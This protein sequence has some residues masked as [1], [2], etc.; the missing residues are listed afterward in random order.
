MLFKTNML[1]VRTRAGSVQ[2]SGEKRRRENVRGDID[3]CR[4]PKVCD[5]S[6]RFLGNSPTVSRTEN[7][8]RGETGGESGTLSVKG[9]KPNN[10]S[11]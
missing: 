8:Q 11:Y 9:Q 4:S 2:R 6:A 5:E 7:V 3:S 1:Q 10:P